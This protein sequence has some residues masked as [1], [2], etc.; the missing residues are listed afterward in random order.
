MQIVSFFTMF[1]RKADAEAE[2]PS[3]KKV[4]PIPRLFRTQQITLNFTN[5]TWEEIAPGELYYL[6]TCQNPKYMF[7]AAMTKQYERFYNIA[8]TFEIHEVKSRMSN[9]IMLQDDLRVQSSTPTDATAFTQVCYMLQYT[10]NRINQYFNLQ[11]LTDEETMSGNTLTY[12]LKPKNITTQLT[13]IKGFSD[14]ENLIIQPARIGLTAGYTPK[15]RVTQINNSISN[16]Y[17]PPD[18]P[19]SVFTSYSGNMQPLLQDNSFIKNSDHTTLSRNLDKVSV[20]KYGD[21]IDINHVTNLEGVTLT[22]AIQNNFMVDYP[23]EFII[24]DNRLKY[25]DEWCYPGPQRPYF[26][27][28]T[29]Y[30]NSIAQT[31]HIKSMG[32]LKH[33]FFCMPPIKKPNGAL[34]GQRCSMMLEQHMSVTLHFTE[35][36]FEPEEADEM[37]G[38]KDGVILRRNIYGK[39]QEVKTERGPFCGKKEVTCASS[40]STELNLPPC[41]TTDTWDNWDTWMGELTIDEF[42]SVFTVDNRLPPTNEML[43]PFKMDIFTEA[44]IQANNSVKEA[45]LS[46]LEEGA[47]KNILVLSLTPKNTSAS[48]YI[49]ATFNA[50]NFVYELFDYEPGTTIYGKLDMNKLME[51]YGKAGL[52][53]KLTEN[54]DFVSTG[55]DTSMFF[56]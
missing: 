35:S 7:D 33:H 54:A 22:K 46:A 6:P 14:F 51:L 43:G 23:L 3:E 18:S 42:K 24:G 48:S 55:K 10:P 30:E 41:P 31:Q 45:Y 1:K 47:E 37:L 56:C 25:L 15:S 40:P 50:K 19:D 28:A 34:L 8:S 16:V 26:T 4:A 5:R 38:Q 17:I 49:V 32:N 27:R 36:V 11:S 21:T 52:T 13:K 39:L 44:G 9:L 20:H 2:C 12:E 53:C 29:N